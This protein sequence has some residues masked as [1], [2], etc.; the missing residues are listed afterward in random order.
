MALTVSDDNRYGGVRLN[1]KRM[2]YLT[3]KNTISSG[4]VNGGLLCEKIIKSYQ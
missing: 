1:K 4:L 3:Q 2:K